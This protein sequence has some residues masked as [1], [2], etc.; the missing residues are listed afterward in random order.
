MLEE[1]QALDYKGPCIPVWTGN[2]GACEEG[3]GAGE[4]AGVDAAGVSLEEESDYD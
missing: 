4:R 1:T 3:D 2:E